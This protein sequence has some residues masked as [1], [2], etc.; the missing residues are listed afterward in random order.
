MNQ[1]SD[2]Q[3]AFDADKAGYAIQYNLW[4]SNATDKGVLAYKMMVQS[5]EAEIPFDLQR[6]RL[7][8]NKV[9]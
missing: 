9:V 3:K 6:V 7:L 1:F 2:M 4:Y 8:S 5:G